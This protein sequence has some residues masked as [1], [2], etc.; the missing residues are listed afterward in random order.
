MNRI[1]QTDR[2]LL[3]V[4]RAE[5]TQFVVFWKLPIY[6][7]QS[8][9]K[10]NLLRNKIRKQIMPTLRIFFNPQIDSA[11][12]NFARITSNE[13][14]Y[15]LSALNSLPSSQI[16]YPRLVFF[17][18]APWYFTRQH[19]NF[20]FFPSPK[21]K[22]LDSGVET[23]TSATP[24]PCFASFGREAKGLILSVQRPFASRPKEAKQG[25]GCPTQKRTNR[26]AT[27]SPKR[28]RH[29]FVAKPFKKQALLLLQK[30]KGYL[31][32]TKSNSSFEQGNK[33]LLSCPFPHRRCVLTSCVLLS[34]RIAHP[35]PIP[36][37]PFPFSPKVRDG[38]A[39][40]VL[41]YPKEGRKKSATT[42]G[43]VASLVVRSKK[44]TE[45]EGE[46]GVLTPKS[47]KHEERTGKQP[48]NEKE[49]TKQ[50]TSLLFMD[51][52]K[53]YRVRRKKA[54]QLYI[55]QLRR[56]NLVKNTTNQR[57]LFFLTDKKG[58]FGK[59]PRNKVVY[60]LVIKN[61][62]INALYSYPI[63]FQRRVL[64][65]FFKTFYQIENAL[66]EWDKKKLTQSLVISSIKNLL[67]RREK[68][69][70]LIVIFKITN[71]HSII[72]C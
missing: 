26:K 5:I 20:R 33:R 47:A 22:R 1:F 42:L 35:I 31:F 65:Q 12:T 24:F 13:Q 46:R 27:P 71:K 62:T 17:I 59:V 63:V 7:D 34:D 64:K 18:F 61:N 10:T 15:F 11:L 36:C 6:P 49:G 3:N 54:F 41:Y 30:A 29:A 43:Q 45:G 55:E 28:K 9:K 70:L 39:K 37:I 57:N 44:G 60:E 21:I 56:G 19:L 40:P 66:R 32:L 16:P 38:V 48:L 25:K 8:N 67:T 72:L 51:G 68:K 23:T 4:Q 53:E 52:S 14:L 50:A 69:A 58:N 2:P